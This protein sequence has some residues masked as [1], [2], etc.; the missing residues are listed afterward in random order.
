ME[1]FLNT[2]TH[3]AM[4]EI[5]SHLSV[6][7]IGRLAQVSQGAKEFADDE[8]V[9]RNRCRLLEYDWS[10]VLSDPSKQ[11]AI[12][13]SGIWKDTFRD[14]RKR[15]THMEKLVGVWS[16]KWCDVHVN[17]S[18]QIE[19]DGQNFIVTYKR[20]KFNARFLN[21]DETTQ[22][23]S[24]HLEGGDSGWAFV[25]TLKPLQENMLHLTVFRVHDK[26]SFTGFFSR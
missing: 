25:Y 26:K 23:L 1:T 22:T 15:L 16:E 11:Q 8:I 24:F 18:T 6:Q 2:L 5:I 9:W 14:E 12:E 10:K 21:F 20:N 3:D 19:T 7:D 17:Q 4:L 13:T